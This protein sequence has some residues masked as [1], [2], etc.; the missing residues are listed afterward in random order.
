MK[1]YIESEAAKGGHTTVSEYVRFLIRQDRERKLAH[2][3]REIEIGIRQANREQIEPL[4]VEAIKA[5]GR[6]ILARRRGNR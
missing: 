3:R 5:K 4:D 2:L 1:A 6:R